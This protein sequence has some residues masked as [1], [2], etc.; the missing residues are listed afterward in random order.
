MKT[1]LLPRLKSHPFKRA[2]SG[3]MTLLSILIVS[4]PLAAQERKPADVAPRG[5][6]KETAGAP[7]RERQPDPGPQRVARPPGPDRTPGPGG[8]RPEFPAELKLTDE[9]QA[10]LKEINVS[11]GAK[12]AELTTKRDSVLTEEQR[13]AQAE[14]M[15]KLRDGNLSRQEAADLIA[16][17]LKLTPEQKAQVEATDAEVRQLHQ[18]ATAQKLAVLTDEQRG[19]LR[20]QTIAANV[21]R[22]FTVPGG[23]ALTEDQK[24]SLQALNG[25]L[26]TKL[27]DLTEKHSLLLTDERR[28]AREA[29]Y[30][31]ARES[32]KDRQETADAVDA[33]LNMTAAEKAQ[34]AETEL[35]LRELNQQIRER[36]TALLTAEQR[37]ELEKKF[38]AGRRE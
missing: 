2:S 7:S 5:E 9:Q 15:K 38:G 35:A 29:A 18:E 22:T 26:G 33:A 25:E 17:A 30:K 32:G 31:S 36:I 24:T 21:T 20:K 34:L 3:A 10:K 4:S 14:A 19:I 1:F 8:P 28:A 23:I 11:L 16:A 12:Q 27:A 13:T 6:R 37:A